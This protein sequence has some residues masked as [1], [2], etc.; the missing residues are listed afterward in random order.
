MFI[1][2]S[3]FSF[4]F[5]Y[6]SI[7]IMIINGFYQFLYTLRLLFPFHLLLLSYHFHPEGNGTHWKKKTEKIRLDNDNNG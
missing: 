3:I 2:F 1:C 6:L 5:D 7:L 4:S